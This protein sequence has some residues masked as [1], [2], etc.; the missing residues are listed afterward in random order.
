MMIRRASKLLAL[1]CAVLTT[2]LSTSAAAQ[3]PERSG[4]W[5]PDFQPP[6]TAWGHPDFQGNW[7]NATLTPLERRPDT[8]PVYTWEQADR[9]GGRQLA[10]N[11]AGSQPSDPNRLPPEAGNIGAYNTVFFEQGDGAAIVNGEPRASLVTFPSNGRIP[12][13]SAEGR[14]RKQDYDAFRSQFGEYDHP[15]L[16]PL[17]ERCVVYYASSRT[18]TMGPPMSP[19]GGY[20]NNVTFVQTPD[21]VVIRAEMIHDIRIIRLGEPEALPKH[22]RP[23]FG[24]SWGH[25]EGNTLVVET[26]NVHPDQG[27]NESFD[28]VPYSEDYR[29]IERFTQVDD[30]TILYE[31]EVDDPKT[32]SESWGGQIPYEK[33]D[34]QIHEYACHEGNYAVENVLSGARYQE[35][36]G[37]GNE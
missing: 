30:D 31:F 13:L 2:G 27:F 16:R 33:F 4:R 15:E 29:V 36:Q 26:T 6:R 32:Y 12:P 20:N 9:I 22:I 8:G 23:W 3:T 21:Y 11:R 17:V 18:G 24:D 14:K 37:R 7:T 10:R 1:V 19:T 5:D 34:Q 25:W 35:R 28:K